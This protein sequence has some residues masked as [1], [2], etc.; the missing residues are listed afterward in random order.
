M[1]A[2]KVL[3]APRNRHRYPSCV[4]YSVTVYVTIVIILAQSPSHTR[5]MSLD[6]GIQIRIGHT[7]HSAGF[8]RPGHR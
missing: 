5:F 8:W 4:H 7:G 1:G 6:T 2:P 3:K